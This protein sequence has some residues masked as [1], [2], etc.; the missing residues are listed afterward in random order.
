MSV[1]EEWLSTLLVSLEP[2]REIKITLKIG[3]QIPVTVSNEAVRTTLSMKQFL[4]GDPGDQGP[5]G[6]QGPEG[7]PGSGDNETFDVNLE[8]L[9][10]I[11]KL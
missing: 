6:P 4:K 1:T 8:L 3:S 9:Y 10:N 7:P 5:A 11:A 2:Q